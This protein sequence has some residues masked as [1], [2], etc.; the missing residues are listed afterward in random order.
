MSHS[1]YLRSKV[2]FRELRGLFMTHSPG[3]QDSP[4]EELLGQFLGAAIL[5]AVLQE[6]V[7]SVFLV[8]GRLRFTLRRDKGGMDIQTHK[9]YKL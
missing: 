7:A 3:G 8:L 2:R 1:V 6:G 4:H 5:V 9:Q